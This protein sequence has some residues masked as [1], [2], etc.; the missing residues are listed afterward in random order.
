MCDTNWINIIKRRFTYSAPLQSLKLNCKL[1]WVTAILVRCEF[2]RKD[3]VKWQSTE[4]TAHEGL[5]RAGVNDSAALNL[6]SCIFGSAQN[7]PNG[8]FSILIHMPV[9]IWFLYTHARRA[10]TF[11]FWSKHQLFCSAHRL[12]ASH[13]HNR[14]CKSSFS[15]DAD[16]N[17][18]SHT[19]NAPICDQIKAHQTLCARML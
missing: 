2:N 11:L 16:Y 17:R 10:H 14:A 3:W 9:C 19:T 15:T 4:L 5:W 7:N 6:I 8:L 1:R 13:D 12:A 18:V